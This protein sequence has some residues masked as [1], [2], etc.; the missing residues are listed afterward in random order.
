MKITRVLTG[1]PNVG[2]KPCTRMKHTQMSNEGVPGDV[3]FIKVN[4]K[5]C[6]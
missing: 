2:S 6:D 3:R 5:K 1:V 4:I